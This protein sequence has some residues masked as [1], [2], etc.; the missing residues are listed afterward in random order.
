M[1][2][3]NCNQ[4]GQNFLDIANQA[5]VA[6]FEDRSVL[7]LVDREDS[8]GAVAAN[9]VLH[10]AGDTAGNVSLRGK[11]ETGNADVEFGGQPVNAFSQ[12]TGAAKAAAEPCQRDPEPV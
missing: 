2:L 9:H 4:S 6:L 5:E 12:R 3:E 1:R 8:A 11:H 7:V 10:L